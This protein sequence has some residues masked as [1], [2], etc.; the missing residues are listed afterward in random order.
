M[1][2]LVRCSF[3]TAVP[4]Y[5]TNY[6]ELEIICPPNG[7]AVLKGLFLC[8]KRDWLRFING[9]FYVLVD[10]QHSTG[11]SLSAPGW[12][13]KSWTPTP[14]LSEKLVTWN[15]HKPQHPIHKQPQTVRVRVRVR[16]R[17][18]WSASG[19]TDKTPLNVNMNM[20]LGYQVSVTIQYL[21][22]GIWVW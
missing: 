10:I 20:Y 9:S 3:G 17:V 16:V 8:P 19:A 14:T 21:V 12:G 6:L 4:F 15:L 2:I 7:R 22:P 11:K 5:Q 18:G 13:H 1:S